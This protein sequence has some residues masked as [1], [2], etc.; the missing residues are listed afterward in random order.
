MVSSTAHAGL[1]HAAV[2][3]SLLV[4]KAASDPVGYLLQWIALERELSEVEE[5]AAGDGTA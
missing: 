2:L 5:R 1:S 4:A 3:A